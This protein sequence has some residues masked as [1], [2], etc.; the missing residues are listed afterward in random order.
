MNK[1]INLIALCIVV[2]IFIVNAGTIEK[3]GPYK[4]DSCISLP[5]TCSNCTFVNITKIQYPDSTINY[6]N[7][8]M[9]KQ[10]PDYNY[11]FCSTSTLGNYI[12][13]TCGDANG[14]YQCNNYY[15]E[16]NSTGLNNLLGFYII[17]LLIGFGVMVFGFIIKDGWVVILGTFALYLVGIFIIINGIDIVKDTKIT[18][19]IGLIILSIAAYISINSAHEMIGE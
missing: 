16:V 3:L 17:I 11:T 10:G 8:M 14:I 7:V 6:L 19:G 12:V 2:C 5:Q 13:T 1:K 15:F 18:F 4:K 9:T